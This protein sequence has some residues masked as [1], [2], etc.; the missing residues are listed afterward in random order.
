MSKDVASDSVK[1]VLKEV[2]ENDVK[3]EINYMDEAPTS[4][5][6]DYEDNVNTKGPSWS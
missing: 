2:F 4:F 1:N 5:K 6:L 3:A